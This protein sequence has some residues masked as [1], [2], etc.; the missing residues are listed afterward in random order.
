MGPADARV[1]QLAA[2]AQRAQPV[3]STR[4]WPTRWWPPAVIG[5]SG[6][7]LGASGEGLRGVRRPMAWWTDGVVVGAEAVQSG[8]QFGQ[9]R[10]LGL[11]AQ[12]LPTVW[13]NRSMLSQALPLV[14][15]RYGTVEPIAH[16][17]SSQWWTVSGSWWG[18]AARQ[19]CGQIGRAGPLVSGSFGDG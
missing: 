5:G 2:V 6:R 18:N 3:L 19:R 4:Y 8:L 17:T 1:E 12:V 16:S 13:W 9:R 14:A 11:T 10:W 7:R 15:G